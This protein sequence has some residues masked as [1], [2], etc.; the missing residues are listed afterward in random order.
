MIPKLPH[1]RIL[2]TSQANKVGQR[3]THTDKGSN[4]L[5]TMITQIHRSCII[6]TTVVNS[7]LLLV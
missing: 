3:D 6:Q 7:A 1:R 5:Q 4:K 2:M